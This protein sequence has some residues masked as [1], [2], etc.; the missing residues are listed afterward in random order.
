MCSSDLAQGY[1]CVGFLCHDDGQ[2]KQR[3]WTYRLVG[4]SFGPQLLTEDAPPLGNLLFFQQ[5]DP[6]FL[7]ALVSFARMLARR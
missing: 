1:D 3:I 5:G 7:S 6:E 2:F 4:L